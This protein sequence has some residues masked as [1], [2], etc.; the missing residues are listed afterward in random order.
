[1]LSLIGTF[2]LDYGFGQ[3][4]IEYRTDQ[5]HSVVSK[6]ADKELLKFLEKG[7]VKPEQ[8]LKV[9]VGPLNN[10]V[11]IKPILGAYKI[12]PGKIVFEPILPFSEE[13]PYHVVF[14]DSVFFEFQIDRPSSR[15]KT[16]LL[17]IYP[18][19]DTVPANLLKMY[20]RFSESMRE[21]EIY[22]RVHISGNEGHKIKDPF[23]RLQPELWDSDA[24]R[25]TLWI[26]PGRVK[27]FLGSREAYGPVI[28]EGLNY[29]LFVDPEMKDS[30]GHALDSLYEKQY[31]VET[32][33][34]KK[35]EISNWKL[36]APPAFS[37]EPMKIEFNEIMDLST[38]QNSF[39]V[40][41]S[42]NEILKGQV[43]VG[44]NEKSW[45]FVPNS[46]WKQGVYRIRVLSSLEDLAG[47]NLNRVFERDL[48]QDPVEPS[49]QE[50]YWMVFEVIK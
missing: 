16:R 3:V 18:S 36:T 49:E 39:S 33:D 25:I 45:W 11:N 32:A 26:D 50:F 44:S 30:F 8:V 42:E 15:P 13:L 2:I 37:I 24:Q 23:V 5:T 47:N 17:D 9:Y 29:R 6:F 48:Y 4:I 14:G 7:L 19:A 28:K 41:N 10:K 27:R 38:T 31:Y 40:W 43:K 21:G 46:I 20:L 12:S 1:M 34:R 35:P 22:E